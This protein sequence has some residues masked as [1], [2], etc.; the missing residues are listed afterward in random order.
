MAINSEP[1]TIKLAIASASNELSHA[2]MLR[3]CTSVPFILLSNVFA[4]HCVCVFNM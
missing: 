4:P 3:V 2:G 1:A